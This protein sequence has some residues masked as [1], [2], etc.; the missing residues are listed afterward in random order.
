MVKRLIKIDK[1][2]RNRP[3]SMAGMNRKTHLPATLRSR[4][5]CEDFSIRQSHLL[6]DV[7]RDEVIVS[8]DDLQ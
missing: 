5:A 7:G 3:E 1:I 6:T 2:G 8:R 4:L